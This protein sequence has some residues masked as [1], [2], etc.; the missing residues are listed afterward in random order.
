[1]LA[2]L[3]QKIRIPARF[4]DDQRDRL[5][6]YLDPFMLGRFND[7]G[8]RIG[9]AQGADLGE[10]E[11]AFGVRLGL[12]HAASELGLPGPDHGNRKLRLRT[13]VQRRNQRRQRRL[14]NVLQLIDKNHQNSGACL[15]GHADLFEQGGQ[16]SLQ[17]AVVG[18]TR[19]D[20]VV[21]F[22][23]LAN[24]ATARSPLTA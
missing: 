24:P 6:L 4:R 2:P 7:G 5:I 23:L 20:I 14:L 11:Q 16:V 21:T 1:M 19:F 12:A 17:I 8:A 13:A 10:T 9:L 22:S 15:R 3:L 18:Q